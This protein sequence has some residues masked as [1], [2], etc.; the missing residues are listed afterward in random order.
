MSYDG[1]IQVNSDPASEIVAY[2][3]NSTS[4]HCRIWRR[5]LT[6]VTGEPLG[7]ADTGGWTTGR[8][9]PV[10][11]AAALLIRHDWESFDAMHPLDRS[12]GERITWYSLEKA[13]AYLENAAYGCAVH[14]PNRVLYWSY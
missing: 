6:E 5:A 8:A 13:T 12:T 1:Y 3:E 11:A 14:R 4:N 2:L 10:F 9:G 7:L